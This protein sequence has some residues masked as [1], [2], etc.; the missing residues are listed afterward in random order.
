MRPTEILSSEHRVI[1][2][3]LDCVEALARGAQRELT[4]DARD[5]LQAVE[6]LRKFADVCHHGKEEKH[7]FARLAERGF[8]A[9]AGPVAVMLHEHEQGRALIR[10]MHAAAEGGDAAAYATAALSYVALLRAHIQK[11]DSI[12][13]R[14]ADQILSPEDQ[15]QL[16]VAFEREEQDLPRGTHEEMLALARSLAEKLGVRE[17]TEQERTACCGHG[18]A[19]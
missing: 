13:F 14:M 3:V 11:E 9:N 6:F 12:L 8:S 5:A 10:G 17:R 4:F 7:L 2:Q 19:A 15:E 18:S 16:L 1:E